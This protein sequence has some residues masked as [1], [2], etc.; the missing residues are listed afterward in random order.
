VTAAGGAPGAEEVGVDG[1]GS[2]LSGGGATAAM[3]GGGGAAEEVVV[4]LVRVRARGG[5]WG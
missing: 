4:G 1:G 5:R 2:R 3:V